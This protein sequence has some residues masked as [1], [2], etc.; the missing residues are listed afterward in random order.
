M[1]FFFVFLQALITSSIICITG[2]PDLTKSNFAIYVVLILLYIV[3]AIILFKMIGKAKFCDDEMVLY[4]IGDY[5]LVIGAFI[6]LNLIAAFI[7]AMGHEIWKGIY[8]WYLSLP[9]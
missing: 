2:L 4:D 7:A 1:Q 9:S 5:A 8:K 6:V 3:S